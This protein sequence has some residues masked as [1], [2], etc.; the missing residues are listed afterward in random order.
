[1]ASKKTK[2]ISKKEESSALLIEQNDVGELVRKMETDY[3]SGTGV[4]MSKY[5]NIDM[6]EDLNTI[7]A[8]ANSKHI[9]GEY[10]SLGR[11]RPFFNIVTAAINIWY[12]ATIIKL[13][14]IR[15]RSTKSKD[16]IDAFLGNIHLQDWFRRDRFATFLSQWGRS[17]AKYGSAISK[18]VEKD[19]KLHAASMAWSKMIVDPV[20]FENNPQIEVLE[21]TEAQ[22]YANKAYDTEMIEKLC[23]ALTTRTTV[24][25]QQIDHKPNYIK[26]YE[27]HMNNKLSYLTG[28]PEDDDTFVQ[29]MHV[30]S[31]VAS[32]EK[33]KFD[34]FTLYKGREAQS[35]YILT[36]LIP[37][38]G[39][40]LSIGAVKHLFQAQWMMNHTMKSIKDQ[41]DLASKII[42]QTSDGNFVGQ[43]AIS[44]IENGD[45]LIHA[46]NAPL[47]QLNNGSHDIS[48]LQN[49]GN[50]WK[51][52]SNEIVGI[53]E[54]MLGNN[55]PSGTAWRQVETL[56]QQ[57]QSLFEVMRENKK[58]AIEEMHRRF[59]LPYLKKKMDT[60]KEIAATLESHDIEKLDQRYMKN[61]ATLEVNKAI[62]DAVLEDRIGPDMLEEANQL[63]ARLQKGL[64]EALKAQG[65]NRYFVPSE[66]SDKTWKQQFKDFEMEL[67]VD[68]KDEPANNDA[69]TTI[70]TVLKLIMQAQGRDLSDDEKMLINK[71]LELVGTVSA[72]ELK[73]LSGP[74]TSVAN[75]QVSQT[76]TSVGATP[77]PVPQTVT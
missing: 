17:L 33:G 9:S 50:A 27:V 39:Q 47:T 15:L 70:T 26:L 23:N 19:G 69:V 51:A 44:A 16:T 31:F 49:F 71:A 25:G 66:E 1:M 13:N 76:P 62:I 7:D 45:I 5:V 67:E 14:K 74:N 73:T 4:Q 32:K 43:N 12:R 34:D 57:N 60:T 59:I 3:T 28:K 18:F 10:D 22:L 21:L 36:H 52:L 58:N 53:S 77:T 38:E 24:D 56:L 30:I 37:E 48:S 40:T 54:S 2:A 42:Y 46:T 6:Y 20:D 65:N 61:Q 11:E 8:Y 64:Q 41:L 75:P 35:P 29:Q 72:L 55:A 68:A 63:N